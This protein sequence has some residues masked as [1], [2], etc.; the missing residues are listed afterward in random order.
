VTVVHADAALADAASTALFVA[1][2]EQWRPVAAALGIAQ[3][4][5]VQADGTVAM[6]P[7]MAGRVRFVPGWAPPHAAGD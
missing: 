7:A 3:A 4:L 1:G 2:P 6:T 5:V